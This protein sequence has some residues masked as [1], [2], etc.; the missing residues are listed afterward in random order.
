M[1]EV[2]AG[3]GHLPAAILLM[4]VSG[5]GKS[6]TGESLAAELGWPFRDADSFHPPANIEKMSRGTPLTDEDR[7]PW[8]AAIAAWMDERSAS[9][10]PLR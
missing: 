1:P 10:Q 6:T 2:D 9:G 3:P 5:S 4:G 8:L 7:W